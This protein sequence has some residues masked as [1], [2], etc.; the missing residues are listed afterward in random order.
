MAR[1]APSKG[2]QFVR[3]DWCF[4]GL[5]IYSGVFLAMRWTMLK[6][7]LRVTTLWGRTSLEAKLSKV[8]G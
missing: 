4:H 1:E 3:V 6:K 8:Q 5:L 7:I 2:G